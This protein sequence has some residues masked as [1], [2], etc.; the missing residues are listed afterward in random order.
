MQKL[1][2]WLHGLRGRRIGILGLAFKPGT[3]DLRDAPSI[4]IARALV[5]GGAR[6]VAHDPA[7]ASVPQVPEIRLA[8]DPYSVAERADAV[9]LMTEWPE[10][11]D[12]E[13]DIVARRM[14]GRLLVDG[15]NTFDPAKAENAGLLWEGVG[16][17]TRVARMTERIT[18]DGKHFALNGAPFHVRGVTYGSF[19]PRADGTAF[20]EHPRVTE[21]F[22]LMAD[23]GLNTVRTYDLP[24]MTFSTSP[25]RRVPDAGRDPYHDWRSSSRPAARHATGSGTPDGERSTRALDR[26]ASRAHVLGISVGNEV[27]ADVVRVHGI[28][29]VEDA[30][31]RAG[32]ARP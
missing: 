27:P 9:V 14:R 22:R 30:P 15:R 19:L 23:V 17:A 11:H 2:R 6:V 1:R 25:T 24:P 32:R 18:V 7:V 3:D 20:P 8:D 13:L 21:D 16:R 31:R 4:D 28:T 5:A 29:A 12:L 10:Y 26:C